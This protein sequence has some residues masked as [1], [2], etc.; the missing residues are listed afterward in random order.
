MKKLLITTGL[1]ATLSVTAQSFQSP[2]I[3][4]DTKLD[5]DFS[6]V[7]MKKFKTLCKN[8]NIADPFSGRYPEAIMLNESKVGE[9]LPGDSKVLIRDFG[10]AIGLNILKAETKVWMEGL[11]YDVK[12][13]KSDLKAKGQEADGIV[14]GTNFIAEEVNLSADKVSLS[15]V[16]PGKTNSPIFSVDILKPR[17]RANEADLIS[18]YMET[19][20]QDLQDHYKLNLKKASFDQMAKNLLSNARNIDLTYQKIVIPE[21]S[22]KIGNKTVNFSPAKIEDLI[23]HNHD[24][25]KGILLAQAA[26]M[27]RSQTTQ[28]ALKVIEQYKIKKDYWLAAPVFQGKF[29]IG[30]FVTSEEGNNIQVN[31]PADFCTNDRYKQMKEG[32]VL[33]K[34]TQTMPT[35]LNKNLHSDSIRTMKDL[36]YHDD[37]NI[38]VSVS[39]DYLNKLL[40]TAYD[41]GLLTQTLEEAGVALGPNKLMLR[42]DKKGESASL[43]M[44]VV[45]K[46]SKME[47]LLTGSREIRFPLVMDLSLR[48]EKQDENP[49]IYVRLNSVDTSDETLIQGRPDL[50]IVSTV[51]DVPRFQSKV[52][53]AIREKISV[54]HDKDIVELKYPELR[55]LGLDKVDFL[56]DGNGRMNAIMR[57]E[58]LLEN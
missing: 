34:I 11:S 20:I 18:F 52:A 29:S 47:K 51:K 24:A 56:S 54:L 53:K 37:A 14:I 3:V 57:M 19:K 1:I 23:R 4:V 45:Y 17:I 15:L 25:I 27:L 9:L 8:F 40:A 38:V 49:A 42:L 22:L 6:A 44:D 50:N 21:V 28:S 30:K 5:Y 31:V 36:I 32:C 26:D 13:F 46:P 48:I 39:E 55:G 35:R 43:I 41:A 10:N 7:L 33:S 12:G 16:I 58:D 2:D